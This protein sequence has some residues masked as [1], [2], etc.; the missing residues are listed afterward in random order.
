MY[1]GKKLKILCIILARSGS[2]TVK[3]KNIA[4]IN[5]KPLIWYTIKEAIKSGVF[6]DII[7]STDSIKY[8]RIAI[9]YGAKVPFLR[10]KK[11]STGKTKAVD[12]LT[13]TLKRYEKLTKK[14]YAYIV[15]LMIT[16]PLKNYIDI[17]K[18]VN[19]QIRS[20]ADSV[21]AIHRV[22]DGHPI[23]AK[24]IV[25]GKIKDF[26]LK[27]ISETHR[28]QLKPK[29]YFRSGSIY[30]MRRDMLLKG[31]RYGTSNSIPYI[32]PKKRVINIDEKIDF[33]F[34]KFLIENKKL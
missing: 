25:N 27:E 33:E 10:P 11:L 16:N 2:K 32:L 3:D 15:E 22:E 26:C 1:N 31:I 13:Y 20:N 29:A 34:A 4:I 5:R 21:I 7:V 30:S 12:C 23:R 24:K 9:K 28:Q 8:K 14:K 17:K 18:V 6:D 19:K